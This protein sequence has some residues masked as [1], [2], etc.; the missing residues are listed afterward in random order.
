MNTS[1]LSQD[2]LAHRFPRDATRSGYFSYHG[3][4]APG[5]RFFRRVGFRVKASFVVLAFLPLLVALL[6]QS[7][8]FQQ[9]EMRSRMDATRQHVEVVH[10]LLKWAHERETRG[11]L[12]REQAQQLARQSIGVLRYDSKEYF[13]IHDRDLR[14]VMHPIKPELDGKDV[15]QLR[16][17]DGL[18]L[19]Q[20]MNEVVRRDGQGVVEYQWPRPGS[21]TPVPK[22]SYVIG[23]EPWGWVIGSGVYVDD[24]QAIARERWGSVALVTLL[25]L[26]VAGYILYSTYLVML[27]GLRE[28][29]R[30][31][32]AMISGDLTTS[33]IPWG[34][35]EAAE[36]MLT[37]REMQQALRHIV[38]QVRAVSSEIVQ[39]SQSIADSATD[40]AS[41]SEQA[42]DHLQATAAS[43]EQIS[44]TSQSSADQA[45]QA[46]QAASLNAQAADTAGRTMREAVG[47]IDEIGRASQQIR[48]IISTID[49]IAFQTNLLAL[50]AS[51]EAARAGES[52]RGFSVVASEVRALAT[53]TGEAAQQIR[54]LIANSVEKSHNGVL[55][56]RQAEQSIEQVLDKAATISALVDQ[57][58]IGTQ[59]QATGVQCIGQATHDLDHTTKQ[60][61]TLVEQ[62]AQSASIL[63]DRARRLAALVEQFR[64]PPAPPGTR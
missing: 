39:T 45:S 22:I 47:V 60:N 3:P 17:P 1:S 31:L 27:G 13:W 8:Q 42:A 58:A 20:A 33:P 4:W 26:L 63:H 48:D 23:F 15:S 53:R 18:A 56:V 16:D 19:F 6:W 59:E 32:R 14:M 30:H 62:A 55:V 34:R 36:L 49:G 54:G 28:T 7:Y 38:G 41:R 5:V 52:G 40:L 44:Q 46:A 12:S 64:L 37:L 51:V 43:M 25:V 21:S 61:A 35:D 50:N 57:I 10:G 29:Q 24:M 11:E 2:T 9:H